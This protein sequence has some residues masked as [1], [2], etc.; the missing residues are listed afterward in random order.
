MK[1]GGM[2]MER[3][4]MN[5]LIDRQTGR[6]NLTGI[7]LES[8]DGQWEYASASRDTPS[9]TL[10]PETGL[11]VLKADSVSSLIKALAG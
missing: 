4:H 10:C 1:L 2:E 11:W 7:I 5:H 3:D 6:D 9:Q 8:W